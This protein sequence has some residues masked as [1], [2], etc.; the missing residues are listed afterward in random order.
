MSFTIDS[1][2]VVADY[3]AYYINNGQNEGNIHTRLME[4]FGSM[5]AFTTVESEDTVLRESNARFTEVLQS[6]QETFTPKGSVTHTPKEI[7]LY[8]IKVDI[9]FYP[10]KLKNQWLAFMTANNL[11]RSQWPYVR[12]LSEIY[13]MRQIN[14]DLETKSIYKGKYVA[15]TAGTA[16]SASQVMDGTKEMINRGIT[17]T[18]TVPILTGAPSLDPETWCEQVEGFAKG[19][20]ELYSSIKMP[21]N[22]SRALAQRY[23]EG[24]RIKYNTNYAQVSD[25]M[26]VQDFENLTVTG[27]ASQAASTK[28]WCT[29]KGNAIFAIKGGSNK[30]LL[31][32]ETQKREVAAFTDWWMGLGFIDDGLVWTNDQELPIP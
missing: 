23:R 10:D 32:L 18:N 15:P 11:D 3:G 1:S 21:I 29:P 31:R 7:K 20:P 22:M 19:L 12:W 26:A 5:D 16:N 24:R 17:S 25:A 28:I 2:Q 6:F 8:N 13:V 30:S 9:S 14:E 4:P 27:R